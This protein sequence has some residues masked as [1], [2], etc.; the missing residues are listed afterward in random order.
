MALNSGVG[1]LTCLLRAVE[2]PG[3]SDALL[4]KVDNVLG[5]GKVDKGIADVAVVGEVDSEVRKVVQTM[6]GLVEP[7]LETNSVELVGNVAH[8]NGGA[9]INA[10][11]DVGQA[12]R[13]GLRVDILG[14]RGKECFV[15][16]VVVNARSG[17]LARIVVTGASTTVLGSD[18]AMGLVG[19]ATV[20]RFAAKRDG[21]TSGSIVGPVL[22]EHIFLGVGRCFSRR[23][24]TWMGVW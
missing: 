9:T 22:V 20:V 8:H 18:G 21:A 17:D 15:V 4:D 3:S 13:L 6:A 23:A 14:T 1:D 2:V 16:D 5:L 10:L 24:S 7:L 11:D 12:D 19:P